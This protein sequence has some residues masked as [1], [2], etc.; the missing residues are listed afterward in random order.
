MPQNKMT[1]AERALVEEHLDLIHWVIEDNIYTRE[2]IPGLEYVDLIQEGCLLLIK[3]ARTFDAA[4]GPFPP[5]ARKV[6]RNGLFTHSSAIWNKQVRHV[7]Q[8]AHKDAAED[9][10]S[11][12]MDTFISQDDTAKQV[13]RGDIIPML[14]S[15]LPE[16]T[17]V[18]RKGIEAIILKVKGYRGVE[19]AAMYETDEKNVSAWI[20]RARQK[21]LANK[22]FDADI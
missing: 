21:L 16:Y 9:G 20:C 8:N 3:A 2:D 13:E 19:I 15:F 6:V 5:Y 12:F 1:D 18:A 7:Y 22:R 17:G 10:E 14:E 4:R 11:D